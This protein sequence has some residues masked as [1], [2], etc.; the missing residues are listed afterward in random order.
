MALFLK[1]YYAKKIDSNDSLLIFRSGHG[2]I[3]LVDEK[4]DTISID[5]KLS[6]DRIIKN[7]M[8]EAE[9]RFPDGSLSYIELQKELGRINAGQIIVILNQFY[10]GQFTDMATKLENTVIISETDEVEFSFFSNRKSKSWNHREWPFVKCMFDGFL[11]KES[12][13]PSQ[14]VYSA[15]EYM[16]SCNPNVKGLPIKADRPLLVETPQIKYGRMN[17]R[18]CIYI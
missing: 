9:M 6:R 5:E 4:F 15:F 3:D 13:G 2:I 7:T 8:A 17:K 12:K 1:H 14:T 16:L 18:E 11:G 10:S